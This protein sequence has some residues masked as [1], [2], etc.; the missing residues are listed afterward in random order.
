[1]KRSDRITISG[2]L[3]G[4]SQSSHRR[5]LG[6]ALAGRVC[7]RMSNTLIRCGVPRGGYAHDSF[8]DARETDGVSCGGDVAEPRRDPRA[9]SILVT[10]VDQKPIER[11]CRAR[12]SISDSLS[13]SN[14]LT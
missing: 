6:L 10:P 4:W 1:M 13:A 3:A 2:S 11:S 8:G 9:Y 14:S 5:E 7:S 12:R